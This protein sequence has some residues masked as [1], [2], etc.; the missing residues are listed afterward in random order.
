VTLNPS[1][2]NNFVPSAGDS[3]DILHNGGSSA[4]SGHF[5]NLPEGTT[6]PNF[7]NSGLNATI[8]YQGGANHQ[9]VVISVQAAAGGQQADLSVTNSGPQTAI[10]GDPNG[11]SYSI[12]VTN[13]G[14]NDAQN[15]VLTDTLPNGGVFGSQ[16]QGNSGPQFTLGNTGNAIRDTITTLANGASQ[17]ITVNVTVNA[18]VAEGTDLANTATATTS[19]ADPT[20]NDGNNS[21]TVHTT[22]H[23][24]ADLQVSKTSTPTTVNAGEQ[25]TYTVTLTN[26]G[27]SDAQNA[28]RPVAA[29][30]DF[31]NAEPAQ[32]PHVQPEREQRAG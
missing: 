15:V 27:P 6:I 19:T 21:F 28:V 29:G 25:V 2:F 9:D 18:N 4:I 1:A 13:N 12:T 3:Y 8:T 24:Q 5:F 7:L 20:P 23:A 32:W 10:A 31:C 22:V 14:P 11:F 17:T 16:S 26:A 30:N